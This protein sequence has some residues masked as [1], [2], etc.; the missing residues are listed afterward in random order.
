MANQNTADLRVAFVSA[1][2]NYYGQEFTNFV[3][4]VLQTIEPEKL[5]D[6]KFISLFADSLRQW[7]KGTV[8]NPQ[9]KYAVIAA[10]YLLKTE[11]PEYYNAQEYIPTAIAWLEAWD[12]RPVNVPTVGGVMDITD[13]IPVDIVSITPSGV[14][15]VKEVEIV[16]SDNG[17]AI[18]TLGEEQKVQQG[19]SSE[20]PIDTDIPIS[21]SGINED[22]L[23]ITASAHADTTTTPKKEEQAIQQDI[24][25]AKAV[26]DFLT[27][28]I[29]WVVLFAAACTLACFFYFRQTPT[30][31][32]SVSLDTVGSGTIGSLL[33]KVGLG[34]ELN[35]SKG[36]GTNDGLWEFLH[37]DLQ[38]KNRTLLLASKRWTCQDIDQ[39]ESEGANYARKTRL[40]EVYLGMDKSIGLYKNKHS[41]FRAQITQSHLVAMLCD[42]IGSSFNF[43]NCHG[44]S[45]TQEAWQKDLNLPKLCRDRFNQQRYPATSQEHNIDSVGQMI[46]ENESF[47][48]L[49]RGILLQDYIQKGIIEKVVITQD[50]GITPFYFQPSELYI[51]VVADEHWSISNPSISRF[52]H[53][54]LSPRCLKSLEQLGLSVDLKQAEKQLA[55]LDKRI[56][57][58]NDVEVCQNEILVWQLR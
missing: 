43:I 29:V 50:D 36:T 3:R 7:S 4:S 58:A 21:L 17:E 53:K 14:E 6:D 35:I 49:T 33:E 22:T 57:G 26:L 18:V 12:R 11:F 19:I 32:T 56:N 13:E 44:S 42:S 10:R 41:K 34:Q 8:K 38:S 20:I 16:P 55:K 47:L 48:A 40:I 37:K 2:N 1:C 9:G 51:Y 45:A 25:P 54:V 15:H 30:H 28:H 5:E 27:N 52:I 39:V 31:I 23:P 24:Q 46:A